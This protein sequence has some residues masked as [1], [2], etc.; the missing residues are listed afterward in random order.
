MD[1]ALPHRQG[2]PVRIYEGERFLR[3]KDK[4]ADSRQASPAGGHCQP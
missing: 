4:D 2:D 1:G 3:K